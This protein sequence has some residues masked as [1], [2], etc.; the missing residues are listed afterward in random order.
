MRSKSAPLHPPHSAW[1]GRG[2]SLSGYAVVNRVPGYSALLAMLYLGRAN[3][4]RQ[5]AVGFR[6]TGQP[7]LVAPGLLGRSDF[8]FLWNFVAFGYRDCKLISIFSLYY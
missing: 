6:P 3:N 8:R 5:R 4:H 2:Y 7:K 1:S